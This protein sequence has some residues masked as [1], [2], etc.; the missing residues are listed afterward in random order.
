MPV[1]NNGL[2]CTHLSHLFEKPLC[3]SQS[4]ER[5][6]ANC[7]FH[8]F[9]LL[10]PLALYTLYSWRFPKQVTATPPNNELVVRMKESEMQGEIGDAAASRFNIGT[11]T[12]EILTIW[13]RYKE[14]GVSKEAALKALGPWMAFYPELA[15]VEKGL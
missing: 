3:K 8:L 14:L 5:R 12:K 2:N 13:N 6:V 9:T 11:K 4:I 15:E 10:L 7:A 1:I